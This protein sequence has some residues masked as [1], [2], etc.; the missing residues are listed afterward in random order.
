MKKFSAEGVLF[1]I[2]LIWGATFVII[3]VALQDISPLLFISFRF[4][5]ASLILLPFVFKPLL[6]ISKAELYGG[7]LLGTIYFLAFTTQTVGLNYT[8][9]TKSGFIT[10]SFI[11]FTAIFQL[12]IEKRVPGKGTL[13]GITLVVAGLVLLSS[14]GTSILYIFLEIGD[15]FNIGDLFTFFCAIFYALYLVYLDIIS[16]KFNY[17]TLSF[18]QIALT[19]ILGFTFAI[20]F[21]ATGIESLRLVFN[22]NVLLALI[23]TSVLATALSTTLQTRY[24]KF[25]TPT[26]A[27]IIFS[28]EPIFA[29]MFAFF[30]LSEKISNFGFI[31]CVLI[32]SGLIVSEVFDRTKHNIKEMK[33]EQ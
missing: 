8:T 6:K 9:A 22:N 13:V 14:K 30:V 26:F 11:I 24:Q 10:G 27:G 29:A 19:F 7:L 33:N 5:L 4:L 25:V 31:G 32:F 16:K 12:L 18:L 28:F 15:N 3:K 2:T 23:Y 20:I 21:S 17:L 1:L